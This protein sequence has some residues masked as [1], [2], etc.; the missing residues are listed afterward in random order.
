MAGANTASVGIDYSA[1]DP[2]QVAAT[3]AFGLVIEGGNNVDA[4]G[5]LLTSAAAGADIHQAAG[6][7]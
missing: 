7:R 2:G 5:T 6:S 3:N 4:A 1:Y